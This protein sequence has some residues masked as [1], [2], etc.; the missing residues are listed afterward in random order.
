MNHM[1]DGLEKAVSEIQIQQQEAQERQQ[2]QNNEVAQAVEDNSLTS[3]RNRRNKRMASGMTKVAA[4]RNAGDLNGDGVMDKYQVDKYQGLRPEDL[5]LAKQLGDSLKNL[6]KQT[7]DAKPIEIRPPID[8]KKRDDTGFAAQNAA[9][10]DTQKQ[11]KNP[12]GR[13]N[14]G[15]RV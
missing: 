15:P 7:G 12:N 14:Q 3:R 10:K 9:E 8:K 13:N 11:P 4:R 1:Q 2:Q 5:L 6:G